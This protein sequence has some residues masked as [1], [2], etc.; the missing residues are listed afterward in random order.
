MDPEEEIIETQ[1]DTDAYVYFEKGGDQ[2]DLET[3]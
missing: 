1:V 3:R 2:S